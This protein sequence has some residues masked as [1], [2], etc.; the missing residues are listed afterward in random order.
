MTA[1]KIGLPGS[2]VTSVRGGRKHSGSGEVGDI[3][4]CGM[5]SCKSDVIILAM[6][7]SDALVLGKLCGK[8]GLKP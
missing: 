7:C 5:V 6:L 4:E 2:I 3:V 1:E 8:T